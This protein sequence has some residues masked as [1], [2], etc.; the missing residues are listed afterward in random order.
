[1]VCQSCGAEL[2]Y[3]TH[4]C[5]WCT[6]GPRDSTGAKTS[7]GHA[8]PPTGT[9][10]LRPLRGAGP[11]FNVPWNVPVSIGRAPTNDIAVYHPT[12][13]RTHAEICRTEDGLRLRDL[14][15][16]NGTFVNGVAIKECF[17]FP[18]DSLQLG[19]VGMRIT[20]D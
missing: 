5:W 6:R 3:A 1:M 17:V 15:S 20:P 8:P 16:A 12:V 4:Y 7:E 18:G 19:R 2:R 10:R 9:V 14:G 11:A 13:S